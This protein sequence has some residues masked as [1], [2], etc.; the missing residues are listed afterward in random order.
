MIADQSLLWLIAVAAPRQ[1]RRTTVVRAPLQ[2]LVS[3]RQSA[4]SPAAN[5][6]GADLK[7]RAVRSR[8]SI[9]RAMSRTEYGCVLVDL[10]THDGR[11]GLARRSVGS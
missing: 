7:R 10:D 5:A 4:L 1:C 11:A 2:V 8:L 6:V 9:T 3:S